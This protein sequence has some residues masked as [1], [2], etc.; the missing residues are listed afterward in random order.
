MLKDKKIALYVDASNLNLTYAQYRNIFTETAKLGEIIKAKVYGVSDRKHKD[1]LADTVSKGYEVCPEQ[2]KSGRGKKLPDARI[3]IDVTLDV[4]QN[5]NIDAVAI[6]SVQGDWV[7]LFSKLRSFGIDVIALDNNEEDTSALVDEFID[8]G[9][10]ERIPNP[11]ANRVTAQT[12]SS[13]KKTKKK[14]ASVKPKQHSSDDIA[15]SIQP[16][17]QPIEQT[18]VAPKDRVAEVSEQVEQLHNDATPLDEENKDLLDEI[19]KLLDEF[20]SN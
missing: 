14:V 3:P 1:I 5:T 13:Q 12:S 9:I 19:K 6:V 18:K 10:V 15:P 20:K 17:V 2:F 11:E 16:D 4:M 8:I 7:Y